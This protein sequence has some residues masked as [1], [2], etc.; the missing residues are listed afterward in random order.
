M[1]FLFKL[2]VSFTLLPQFFIYVY[3]VRTEQ[4]ASSVTD[5]TGLADLFSFFFFFKFAD[6]VPN[7]QQTVTSSV[8]VT[9][10]LFQACSILLVLTMSS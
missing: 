2:W 9:V 1:F 7:T 6:L 4:T 8:S 10:K 3:L 5:A